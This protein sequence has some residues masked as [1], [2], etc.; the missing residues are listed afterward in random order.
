MSLE[1]HLLVANEV[2]DDA[3]VRTYVE[4]FAQLVRAQADDWDVPVYTVRPD[5]VLYTTS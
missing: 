1:Q 4:N 5:K 3:D 2:V